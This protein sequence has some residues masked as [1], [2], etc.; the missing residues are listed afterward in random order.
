MRGARVFALGAMLLSSALAAAGAQAVRVRRDTIG[1]GELL[2]AATSADP[3]QRQLGL[4][5]TASQLRLRSI[6]SERLPSLGV[7]G[8]AQ[9]QSAV[10]K[11]AIPLPGVSVPVPPNDTYDAHL[12][13]QQSILDPTLASR[14]AVERARLAESQALVRGTLFGLRQELTEAFFTAASLQQRIAETDAAMVDL[15][16]RLRE[17]VTRY[18]NGAALRGDTASIAAT[19]NERKQDRLALE[20]ER[21]AALARLSLLTDRPIA[22]GAVLVIPPT[23]ALV[24]SVAST[25]DTLRTRPEYEQFAATRERLAQQSRLAAAQEKPRVS[26]FGRVGYGRPGLNLLSSDFQTYWV[27]GVQLH[28]APFTWGTSDRDRE[29]LALEREIVATNEAAFERSLVRSV[30]PALASIV[31]LDSTIALDETTIALR[32]QVA[33]EAQ[34]QLREGVITAA[35]Y[36]DRSTELLVARLRGVQHRVALEQ[37]RVTLLNTLGVEV[38]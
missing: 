33:G 36:V 31:R 29:Q 2:A 14:R 7:D 12:S 32:E 4:Q 35:T 11:I 18:R 27:A 26:A 19:L 23:A 24:S 8:Q 9:Y 37:A 28:W 25:L 15:S 10:T 16:A 38:R 3:R 22:D 5:E 6:A 21:G 1:Y 13:A 30:Q 34:T 20:S 17:T